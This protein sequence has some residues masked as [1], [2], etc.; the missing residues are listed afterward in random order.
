MKIKSYYARTVEEAV[1]LARQELGPEA[2]LVNSRRAPLEARHLGDYEVVVAVEGAAPPAVPAPAASDPPAD[3]LS[4]EVAELR[5]QLEGMR[6]SIARG[7]LGQAWSGQSQDSLDIYSQL[8]TAEVAPELARELAQ[9]AEAR[10][11]HRRPA[12]RGQLRNDS[13]DLREALAE[14][15]HARCAVSPTLGH[16]SARP[17][18]VALVGPPGAGKTSTLVKLAVN[19]GLTGRRPTVLLSADTYR[20]AAA[21][22]LRSYA[23]IL[24]VGFQIVD[25][26]GVLAQALE[27][28]RGK[29][30]ILIDTPGLGC[31][32]MEE[33]ADLARFL[34]TRPD[35]D[36]HLVLPASM[37]AADLA[38]V[39]DAYEIFRPQRLLF[40]RLDETG[41]FGPIF[42]EVVRTGKAL[43]FFST[44]QRI[45]EDLETVTRERVAGLL[46]A[47][48]AAGSRAAA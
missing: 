28:A 10:L 42:N 20:I 38:R 11:A 40:T 46:L 22:Q 48:A 26:I 13:G 44:G 7:A 21:E 14:E 29:D 47:G 17:A 43:S 33:S 15:L 3:R 16:G 35:I 1:G 27:E 32:D 39:I 31:T 12:G 9:A 41:S 36:T 23:A 18:T 24:G 4:R 37:K 8:T 34:S 30:L 19:Y 45:P 25:T 6:R 5:V 2:M